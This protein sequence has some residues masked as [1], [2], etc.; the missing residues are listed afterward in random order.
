MLTQYGRY[1]SNIGMQGSLNGCVLFN[2]YHLVIEPSYK[3]AIYSE[4]SHQKMCC[5]IVM[6]AYGR[7]SQYVTIL[8]V[9]F[10]F[11]LFRAQ[12]QKHRISLAKKHE[13]THGDAWVPRLPQGAV[14]ILFA[15]A[16]VGPA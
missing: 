10:R 6:L 13:K 7:G 2:I 3:L 5:S 1:T 16:Q 15:F 11:C 8:N 12:K 14:Q 4:F 9:F